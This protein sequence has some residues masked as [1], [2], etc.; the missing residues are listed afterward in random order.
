MTT[1]IINKI[2]DSLMQV[3]I[4][5]DSVKEDQKNARRHDSAAI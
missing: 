4:V 1:A 3:A 2:T 5:F